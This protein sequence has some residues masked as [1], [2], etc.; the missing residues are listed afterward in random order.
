[1]KDLSL[2]LLLTFM[3]SLVA[4]IAAPGMIYVTGACLALLAVRMAWL[5]FR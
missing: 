5:V 2:W 4:A 3:L 1:M